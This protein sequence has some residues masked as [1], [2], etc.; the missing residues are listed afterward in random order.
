[1]SRQRR[2]L[3]KN[4]RQIEHSHEESRIKHLDCRREDGGSALGEL[5]GE[6]RWGWVGLSVEFS[7]SPLAR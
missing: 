5:E 3:D 1:M 6:L 2:E 7:L 4:Q